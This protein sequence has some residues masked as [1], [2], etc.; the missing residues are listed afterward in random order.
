MD[1][2]PYRPEPVPQAKGGR[3]RQKPDVAKE[4]PRPSAKSLANLI[5]RW[6]PGESGNPSGKPKSVLE[7]QR[8]AR[9]LSPRAIARLE[10]IMDNPKAPFRDQIMASVALLDRGNGR[11]P[12]LQMTADHQAAE[13]ETRDATG[14]HALLLI[15]RAEHEKR[16]RLKPP[17]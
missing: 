14:V 16:Q 11:P 15:A 2:D 17:Q 10:S 12:L 6:K 8:L 1:E 3:R 13:S 7:I 4:R 9:E 5:P